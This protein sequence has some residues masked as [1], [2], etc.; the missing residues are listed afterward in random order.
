MRARRPR[1]ERFWLKVDKSGDCWL[2]K[3]G[4]DTNGYGAFERNTAHRT[5]YELS[6]GPIPDGLEIDHLCH[7]KACVNPAHLEA[8]THRVNLGRRVFRARG[9][10]MKPIVV[11]MPPS[12]AAL[13]KEKA[14]ERGISAYVRE[15]V[16]RDLATGR[17][18]KQ[19]AA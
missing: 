16:M 18:R 8:V 13:L 17:R 12:I 15:L 2:W 3:A 4:R 11:K 6:V 9:N 19:V 1:E 5:A 10:W 14:G 7:V